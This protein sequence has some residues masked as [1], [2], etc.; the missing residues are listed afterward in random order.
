MQWIKCS[1]R[2]D[3]YVIKKDGT[4]VDIEYFMATHVPFR[5]LEF[6]EFGD[7]DSRSI[8]LNEEQ[9]YDQYIINKSGKHQM[10]IVRGTNGTGKSHL[11]CW[12]HNRFVSDR[13]NYNP[14]KEKV[15]FLRRLGN[16][17]RGAV[18]QMLDEGIVRD[19]ELQEK[20]TKFVS[21]AE[22]QSE[23]ELKTTIYSEYA[24][25][26]LTDSTNKVFKAIACKNIAAFLHD[27]RVQ[28]Y[29]MRPEG[30]VDRC[31]RRIT[32]GAKSVVT[33]E[34]DMIFSAADFS[35][36]IEVARA[37]KKESAEEVKSFYLYDLREDDSEVGGLSES[38]YIG[39]DSEL[40]QYHQ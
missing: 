15:V 3:E 35:F 4:A 38:L 10:L 28:D 32:T 29:M 20:F 18:Q 19:K 22:S 31:Y 40:C 16:T 11:I 23:E 25:R 6:I 24:K 7:T 26:V 1:D 21:A 36:P 8:H 12:L 27:T 9:I 2:M 34:A 14:E 5:D 33:D 30:P 37:V 13:V 39:G 17:V